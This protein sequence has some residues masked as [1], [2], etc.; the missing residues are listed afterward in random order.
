MPTDEKS[1]RARLACTLRVLMVAR[2]TDILYMHEELRQDK[3]N[4]HVFYVWTK[5]KLKNFK[6]EPINPSENLNV[7]P[8]ALW[9]KYVALSHKHR[10]A[11]VEV[12]ECKVRTSPYYNHCLRF[13]YNTEAR[14]FVRSDWNTTPVPGAQPLPQYD[15]APV[16]PQQGYGPLSANKLAQDVH[17]V[18]KAAGIDPAYTAGALRG[19][20]ASWLVAK[21]LPA[22]AVMARADW[23]SM[24]TFLRHYC[25]APL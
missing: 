21:G 16:L 1:L 13:Q 3:N 12:R 9:Q 25:R 7:C 5:R 23:S 24:A 4:A 19:A 18:M 2:T 6:F 14:L 11:G 8:V 15:K 10:G 20:T 22:S 17:S